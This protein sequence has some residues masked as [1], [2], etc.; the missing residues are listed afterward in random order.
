MNSNRVNKQRFWYLL[1]RKMS[2]HAT[3]KELAELYQIVTRSPDA[4]N[5]AVLLERL[6][7]FCS[8]D[9]IERVIRQE[10]DEGL[11]GRYLWPEQALFSSK[12]ATT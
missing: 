5:T 12:K 2:G 10:S 6:W 3:G 7:Q 11:G 8:A 9:E 1:E 4:H